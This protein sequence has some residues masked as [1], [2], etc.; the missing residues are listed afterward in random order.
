MAYITMSAYDSVLRVPSWKGLYQSGDGF[1]SDPRYATEAV[2]VL[3]RDGYMRQIGR[4]H[5]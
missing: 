4:A 3:T 1:S 5:V 2:N